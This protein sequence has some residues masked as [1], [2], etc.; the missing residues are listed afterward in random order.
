PEAT[1]TGSANVQ[2]YLGGQ[3]YSTNG[4]TTGT[5][6]VIKSIVVPV[7]LD[8]GS[9]PNTAI[10]L[11]NGVQITSNAIERPLTSLDLNN[12][13]ATVYGLSPAVYLFQMQELGR[14]GPSFLQVAGGVATGG[15]AYVN[16]ANLANQ[17]IGL[18]VPSGVTLVMQD[19]QQTNPLNINTA[20]QVT[21]AGT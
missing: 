8:G 9:L 20:T 11:G 19:F 16:P 7:V 6:D 12:P 2:P 3:I 1:N 17:L 13:A 14:L 15:T 5:S 21:I 10:S 18:S 4:F